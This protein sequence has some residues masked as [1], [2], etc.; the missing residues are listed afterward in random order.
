MSLSQAALRFLDKHTAII[1][2]KLAYEYVD[3]K[4]TI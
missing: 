2:I 3:G 4:Y 1:F